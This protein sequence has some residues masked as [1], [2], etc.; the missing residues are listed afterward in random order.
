MV[1]DNG[2]GMSSKKMISIF[3][4]CQHQPRERVNRGKNRLNIDSDDS[5]GLGL[6]ICNQIIKENEGQLDFVSKK[7]QGSIFIF[8]FKFDIQESVNN[9]R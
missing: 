8:T 3:N 4:L 1:A 6:Y 2:Q 9:L 5:S 7:K